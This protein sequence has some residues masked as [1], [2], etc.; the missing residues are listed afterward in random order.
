MHIKSKIAITY[1][2]INI[3]VEKPFFLKEKI[4]GQTPNQL[5]IIKSITIII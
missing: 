3:Y 1:R 4:I 5:T 2:N